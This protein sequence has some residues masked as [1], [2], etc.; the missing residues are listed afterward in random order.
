MDEAA[1]AHV[2]SDVIDV[3]RADA[4]EDEVAGPDLAQRNTACRTVLLGCGARD[5]DADLLVGV[6]GKSAAVEAF[7]ARSTEPIRGAHQT[8][9]DGCDG[10]AR[11]RLDRARARRGRAG[12]E[13]T[14]QRHSERQ[15]DARAEIIV[16]G[17]AIRDVPTV[18]IGIRLK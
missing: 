15:R 11:S 8:R 6:E 18:P 9:G 13:K 7:A 10:R 5:R 12:R 1:A 16:Q 2:D 17:E 14:R 3:T 4:K